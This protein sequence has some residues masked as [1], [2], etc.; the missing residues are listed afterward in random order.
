MKSTPIFK[1]LSAA[2]L[3]AVVF[4]FAVQGY[5]YFSDPINTTFVYASHEWEAIETE[6]YLVR[7]EE[8]FHSDMTT[9]HHALGEGEKVG[10][11]QTLAIAFPDSGALNRVERLE[12]LEMQAQQLSFAL[13]S[14]LDGDAALKLD[15]NIREDLAAFHQAIATGDYT[16]GEDERTA[17]KTAILKR[18]YTYTSQEQIELDLNAVEQK[19]QEEEALLNGTDITAPKSGIFS[20]VCDGYERVLTPALLGEV[21]PS[22]LTTLQPETQNANVGKLIYGDT[23]YYVTVITQ[24]QAQILEDRG[25]ISVQFAKGFTAPFSM[26]IRHISEAENGKCVLWLSTKEYMA[27]TTLLRQQSASLLLHEYEGLRLPDK[28]LRVNAEGK[29]GVYCVIGA[30]ARYKGVSVLYHGDDYVLVQ[31]TDTGD[32]SLLRQG[33]QVIVTT[34]ELYDGKV[35]G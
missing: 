2:V 27:Q 8:T 24:E 25:A 19:I 7:E 5:H 34:A 11:N 13:E 4:Y 1:I 18:D 28:A 9:L 17:L 29:T 32:T 20:A 31:P 35:I 23:W 21:S 15:D 10:K 3:L 16:R 30:R 26:A 12:A 6:G 14:F 33:D 22:F